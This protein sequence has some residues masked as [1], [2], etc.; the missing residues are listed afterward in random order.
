M[1]IKKIDTNVAASKL[2]TIRVKETISTNNKILTEEEI[3]KLMYEEVEGKEIFTE[4]GQDLFNYYYN[5]Y[6]EFLQQ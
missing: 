4:L 1:A 6:Y 5:K 3:H 2:A